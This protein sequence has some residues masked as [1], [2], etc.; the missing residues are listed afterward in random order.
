MAHSNRITVHRWHIWA[1]LVLAALAVV[2]AY[3]GQINNWSWFFFISVIA[4]ILFAF[5]KFLEAKPA[6]KELLIREDLAARIAGSALA[7]GMCDYYDMQRANEQERRNKETKAEISSANGL[8]LCANSGASYLDPA[9]YRHW[10]AV[11]KRLKEGVEFRVI[12]L[13]P[14]SAE[15]G[16]RNKLNVD[17]EQFDSKMNVPSLIKLYNTYPTLDIRFV[18]YGMH[19]TVFATDRVIFFDPYH[20]SVIDNRIENRSIC[21]KI[22]PMTPAEGVGLYR[23]FKGHLDTLWR[24]GTSFEEWIEQ[25]REMLPNGL[26]PLKRRQYII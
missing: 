18:R 5:L 21:L 10:P 15:K 22:E 14:Y 6:L 23:L 8:W 9:I 13:D 3:L 19:A 25:S 20:V 16:F 4:F 2:T 11:E 26:P 24:S 7:S 1:E 17:G 12:L